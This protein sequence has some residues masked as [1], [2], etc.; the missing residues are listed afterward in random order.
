MFWP[1][2]RWREDMRRL[3]RA[4]VVALALAMGPTGFVAAQTCGS[5]PYNLAAG[6]TADAS[7]V[8]ANFNFVLGCFNT[9][10]GTLP[11]TPQGRLTLTTGKPV[12]MADVVAGG[13]IYYTPYVGGRVPLF[14]GT[15]FMPSPFAE[16]SAAADTTL[17]AAGSVYDLFVF[18]NAGTVMLGFGPAWTSPTARGTGA[19]TTQLQQVQGLWT[20]QNV[21]A[22]TRGSTTYSGIPANQATYVGTVAIKTAGQLDM[23]FRPT[24]AANGN[25]T[26]LGVWN[27][28]NR[29]TVR[30]MSADSTA[31]WTYN[32]ATIRA[33]HGS[34]ANRIN[35]VDGLQQSR[36]AAQFNQQ[37]S[38]QNNS[39]AGYVGWDST[40]AAS[41]EAAIVTNNNA[42]SLVANSYARDTNVLLGLHYVQALESA[43]S[44]TP[45]F[46]GAGNV[47][48]VELEM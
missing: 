29:V 32:S 19:G 9:A 5:Y 15:S 6:N 8:M 16:I 45:T 12:M 44:G 18:S 20:N 27:A 4:F 30:S 47:L 25:N 13:T 11:A 43:P 41:G 22:L 40:T 2:A 37:T 46:Y 31:S 23:Q 26:W 3:Q 14:N 21:I 10:L 28:Y 7:Q 33:S 17:Q 48:E 1:F 38:T 34:N 35:W 24:P 36:I 39:A 42:S